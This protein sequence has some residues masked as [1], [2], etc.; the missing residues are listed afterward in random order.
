MKEIKR[1][2][3]DIALLDKFGVAHPIATEKL[4]FAKHFQTQCNSG[5]CHE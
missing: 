2:E 3:G 1:L 4:D 5:R